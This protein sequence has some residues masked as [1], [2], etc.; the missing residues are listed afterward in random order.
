MAQVLAETA[1]VSDVPALGSAGEVLSP[2]ALAQ[3]KERVLELREGIEEASRF[4]DIGR[5]ARLEEELDALTQQIA[6]AFGLH[7]RA[8]KSSDDAEK[9]RKSV[10]ASIR[11]C[12]QKLNQS[13]PSLGEHLQRSL[14]IGQ[15]LSYTPSTVVTWTL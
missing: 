5:K 8:R 6:S 9:I 12:L 1:G 15:F 2:D 7:G 14:H 3:Y 11:R 10:G 13:H 4:N